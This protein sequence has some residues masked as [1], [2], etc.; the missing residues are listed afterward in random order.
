[1]RATT[2]GQG[3]PGRFRAH[4]RGN[5]RDWMEWKNIQLKYNFQN[6]YDVAKPLSAVQACERFLAVRPHNAYK[7]EIKLYMARLYRMAY[8]CIAF[9]RSKEH[10]H[11]LTLLHAE[12][13]LK[14]SEYLYRGLIESPDMQVRHTARVALHNLT[15]PPPRVG[16][17][18]WGRG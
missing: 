2:R 17:G 14:R 10:K 12:R 9:A 13:F 5:H 3:A 11:G 4:P 6:D 8:E 1:M 18:V 7:T 15:K 16:E